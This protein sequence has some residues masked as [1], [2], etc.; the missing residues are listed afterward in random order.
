MVIFLSM[1]M[2]ELLKASVEGIFEQEGKE[3]SR[4]GHCQCKSFYIQ[5]VSKPQKKA[6]LFV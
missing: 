4:C 3:I 6:G 5:Y 1:G 2:H